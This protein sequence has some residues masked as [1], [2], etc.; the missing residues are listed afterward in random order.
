MPQNPK[1]RPLHF[2]HSD[3]QPSRNAAAQKKFAKRTQ[4]VIEKSSNPS[5]T[6]AHSS[7]SFAKAAALDAVC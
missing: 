4:E 6:H 1:P 5:Q 7:L 2:A 3:A